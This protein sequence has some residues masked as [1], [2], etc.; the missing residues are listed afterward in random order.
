MDFKS[1]TA[2][3]SIISLYSNSFLLW[4]RSL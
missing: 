4:S 2:R 3:K 1:T